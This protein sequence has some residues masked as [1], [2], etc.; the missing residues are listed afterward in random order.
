MDLKLTQT[1]LEHNE[2]HRVNVNERRLDRVAGVRQAVINPIEHEARV[3]DKV[4]L[5]LVE[6]GRVMVAVCHQCGSALTMI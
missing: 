2:R 5:A 4:R 6:L 3:V 1:K